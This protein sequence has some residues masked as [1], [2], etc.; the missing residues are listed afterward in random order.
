MM[1]SFLLLFSMRFRFEVGGKETN[2]IRIKMILG[3]NW[4]LYLLKHWDIQVFKYPG[5]QI[6]GPALM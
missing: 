4:D 2:I 5:I 1:G 6:L 3:V